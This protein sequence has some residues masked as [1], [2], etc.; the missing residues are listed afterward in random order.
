MSTAAVVITLAIR[1]YDNAGLD[2]ADRTA[3][4]ATAAEI[5]LASNVPTSWPQCGTPA[6]RPAG[7]APCDRPMGPGEVAV[8]IVRGN[9]DAIVNGDLA[10][11][12][13]LIDPRMRGGVLA[14]IYLDRAEW[15]AADAGVP[16]S[17]V[18]GRAI[19]H[20]VGHLL[21]GT[22]EHSATGLMRAIWLRQTF[23]QNRPDDWLFTFAERAAMERALT[24]RVP[25]RAAE[26][27]VWGAN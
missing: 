5:L 2:E 22:R 11:G 14:T 3:A 8:R 10:L 4:I 27:I 1:L 15:I 19:A 6:P 21:L 16:A 7:A 26:N 24:R 23:E 12:Y 18:V 17:L 9:R 20:E 13:S 25:P